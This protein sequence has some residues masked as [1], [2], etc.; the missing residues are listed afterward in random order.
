[1]QYIHI[2][3]YRLALVI[4]EDHMVAITF[5]DGILGHHQRM[6]HIVFYD[7]LH[8]HTIHQLALGIRDASHHLNQSLV[9]DRRIH[10][11]HLPLISLSI[12][13]KEIHP[14]RLP[15]MH[16]L[17]FCL[18]DLK[19]HIQLGI[20][21]QATEF[22]HPLMSLIDQVGNTT[23]EWG[24]QGAFR[25]QTLCSLQLVSGSKVSR[26][27]LCPMHH[28]GRH[29]IRNAI[30]T[31]TDQLIGKGYPGILQITR[32]FFHTQLGI[33]CIR[34]GYEL[35]LSHHLTIMHEYLIHAAPIS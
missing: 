23:R 3:P 4:E 26:G 22:I 1:M 9:T 16:L 24:N 7:D 8:I 12:I 25:Q 15:Y 18:Q 29:G 14:Y 35:S 21:Y 19:L 31:Q 27:N 17:D 2:G 33:S 34:P 5:D 30:I 10:I 20:I 32:C 11:H 13:R 6:R 28:I